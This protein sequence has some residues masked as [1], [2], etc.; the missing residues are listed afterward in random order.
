MISLRAKTD[1]RSLS[2]Y[3][4]TGTTPVKATNAPD[5]FSTTPSK[6][7]STPGNTPMKGFSLY[8][9]S[10]LHKAATESKLKQLESSM[11]EQFTFTPDTS[12]P[13][14][15]KKTPDSLHK[16]TTPNKSNVQNSPCKSPVRS[17]LSSRV[18]ELYRD[19]V[20][21]NQER[22]MTAKEEGAAR[23]RRLQDRDLAQCTFRPN[24]DWKVKKPANPED[25]SVG[26]TK[27]ARPVKLVDHPKTGMAVSPLSHPDV[28]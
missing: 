7:P 10:L 27:A 26:S 24:L 16:N 25:L 2:P 14:V 4:Q 9:R 21:K 28:E 19:G 13:K 6:T 8:E 20:R 1:Q 22:R 15:S 12:K 3:I 5:K 23:D 18:D 11:M 17:P